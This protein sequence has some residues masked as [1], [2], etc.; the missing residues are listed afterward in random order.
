MR[1]CCFYFVMSGW[2][3]LISAQ[4]L[5]YFNILLLSTKDVC[6]YVFSKTT[7]KHKYSI[8]RYNVQFHSLSA[9]LEVRLIRLTEQTVFSEGS[10]NALYQLLIKYSFKMWNLNVTST[11]VVER[12][13][14]GLISSLVVEIWTQR[15]KSLLQMI[16]CQKYPFSVSLISNRSPS[17]STLSLPLITGRV[18][19]LSYCSFKPWVQQLCSLLDQTWKSEIISV[20]STD[21][22]WILCP[23][24][25][26]KCINSFHIHKFC[27][28]IL[29]FF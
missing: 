1:A 11:H 28:K 13:Y 19:I 14:K 22:W 5:I 23:G 8:F 17:I 26:I 2:R 20:P 9:T 21:Y 15:F 10:T 18:R 27:C 29:T 7:I 6:V 12:K 4:L 24:F 3:T 25:W 16:I